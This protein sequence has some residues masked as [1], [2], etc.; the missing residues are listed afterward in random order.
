MT[1]WQPLIKNNIVRGWQVEAAN[2]EQ[3][4]ELIL[5]RMRI[6]KYWSL[7]NLWTQTGNQV[8][9]IQEVVNELAI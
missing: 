2:A 9:P 8:E 4:Q 6:E 5:A 1:T 7:V 3:A